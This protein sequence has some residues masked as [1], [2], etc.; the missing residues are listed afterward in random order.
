MVSI[1]NAQKLASITIGH[2]DSAFVN[3]QTGKDTP[4]RQAKSGDR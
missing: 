4:Q 2:D 1:T 3:G